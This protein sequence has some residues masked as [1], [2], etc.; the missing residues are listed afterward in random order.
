MARI[1]DVNDYFACPPWVSSE[2]WQEYRQSYEEASKGSPKL[3]QLDLE[4]S[5]NCN[6]RCPECPIS[7]DNPSGR[8]INTMSD[9]TVDRLLSEA[10][11]TGV[12]ALKLNYI[13]EP[14]LDVDRILRV[15]KK[16]LSLGII[17]IY[18]TTNGSLLTKQTSEKLI[19]S[20]LISR[21]QVSLD[22]FTQATYNTV[23][24]GGSLS[25]VKENIYTFLSQRRLHSTT[26]PRL[27]VSFLSLPEN[28][29][30]QN[31]FYQEWLGEVDA[32]ALQSS[33]LKPNSARSNISEYNN[34]RSH[35]CPNPFR[36]IVV[37]ASGDVL[38]CCSFWG[39]ELVLGSTDKNSLQQLFSSKQGSLIREQ[40]HSDTHELMS[41]CRQCLSSCDPTS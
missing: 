32:I 2:A 28:Q 20:Q 15:A 18:L 36:Q 23:R 33:V 27:R 6:Y 19:D 9:A 5:D 8:T 31:Q 35:F 22:A 38:P 29:H 11:A 12:K 25:R 1:T 21:I 39:L 7:D 41:P 10:A 4:L 13:N 26:W 3:I 16:A 37:R 17:D 30:E 24:V 14:L 40:F 34:V